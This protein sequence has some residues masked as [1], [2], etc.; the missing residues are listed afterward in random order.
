MV[1][2]KSTEESNDLGRLRNDLGRQGIDGGVLCRLGQL[3]NLESLIFCRPRLTPEC[4]AMICENPKS[5][6]RLRI[7]KALQLTDEAAKYLH[8]LKNLEFLALSG[9]QKLMDFFF[10]EGVGFPA[11]E[12]LDFEGCLLTDA[13]LMGIRENH[14]Y[15]L[16]LRLWDRNEFTDSGLKL[17]LS[18]ETRLRTLYL[19][20]CPRLTDRSLYAFATQCHRLSGIII[21]ADA[22]FITM[23]AMAGLKRRRPAMMIDIKSLSNR[24]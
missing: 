5:L 17:F 8:R 10:I 15:L 14:P 11:M 20:R 19:D 12:H 3:R 6:K 23:E 24:I 7:G 1:A 9:A 18:R 22:D 16:E 2:R 13:A 21:I 4:F